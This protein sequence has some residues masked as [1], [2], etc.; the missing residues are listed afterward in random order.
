[1]AT[2]SGKLC[3]QGR[4]VATISPK[5]SVHVV[6]SVEG[7]GIVTRVLGAA[8]PATLAPARTRPATATPECMILKTRRVLSTGNSSRSCSSRRPP[9]SH[10]EAVAAYRS[11]AH[12]FPQVV[13]SWAGR[14]HYFPGVVALRPSVATI[15]PELWLPGPVVGTTSPE[16]CRQGPSVATAS[17]ELWPPGAR[18]WRPGSRRGGAGLGGAGVGIPGGSNGRALGGPEPETVIGI[19]SR[20]CGGSGRPGRRRGCGGWPRGAVPAPR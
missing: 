10:P 9:N 8:I 15:S 13:A 12:Y 6:E 11:V 2:T 18:L 5:V 17:P 16:L 20:R 1:M 19:F 7:V 14:G 3:R 4:P